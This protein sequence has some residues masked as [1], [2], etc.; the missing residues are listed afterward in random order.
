M[1]CMLQ[2]SDENDKRSM[3]LV[4]VRDETTQNSKV[5]SNQK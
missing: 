5:T 1:D 3:S 2:E 4:G